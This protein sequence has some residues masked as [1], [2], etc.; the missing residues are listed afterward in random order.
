MIRARPHLHGCK[1]RVYS[2]TAL[3]HKAA[4]RDFI[5]AVTKDPELGYSCVACDSKN[6]EAR[7]NA[8]FL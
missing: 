4:T 2:A 3:R 5:P 6:V 1:N 8:Q 7:T